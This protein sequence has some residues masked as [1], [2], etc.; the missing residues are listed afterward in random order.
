MALLVAV[1]SFSPG[2]GHRVSGG[3][4]LRGALTAGP[5]GRLRLSERVWPFRGGRCTPGLLTAEACAVNPP[6]GLAGKAGAHRRVA[7]A[8]RRRWGMARSALGRRRFV[9]IVAA[10][11]TA[12]GCSPWLRPAREPPPLRE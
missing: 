3:R 4:C 2:D 11:V 10:L 6:G 9:G 12:G 1:T 5:S 8:V 7:Q